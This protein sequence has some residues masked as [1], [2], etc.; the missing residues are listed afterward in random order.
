DFLDPGSRLLYFH[1]LH[2]RA[3][4]HHRHRNTD[5]S[6]RAVRPAAVSGRRR[7]RRSRSTGHRRAR[8]HGCGRREKRTA[9]TRVLA[10]ALFLVTVGLG[11]ASAQFLSGGQTPAARPFSI[12]RLDP[13]LDNIIDPGT[14][15]ELLGDRF[16]LTEGS[17]WVQEGRNGYLLFSDM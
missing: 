2:S 10:C 14:K 11:V 16:G 3:G 17:V 15:A 8:E 1:L 6:R 4:R 13:A 7:P 12:D 9:M 5:G